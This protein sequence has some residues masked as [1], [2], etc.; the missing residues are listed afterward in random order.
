MV[1]FRAQD[2]GRTGTRVRLVCAVVP[3]LAGCSFVSSPLTTASGSE[4]LSAERLFALE[5]EPLLAA[6]CFACH[7]QDPDTV[8]SGLRLTSREAMLRGGASSKAVLV[9]GDADASLL[10]QAVR[11]TDTKLK[12]PPLEQDR[13]AA[14]DIAK[15]RA[16]IAAG[17]P[18]PETAETQQRPPPE[19]ASPP[20]PAGVT[21]ATS[22]GLSDAWTQRRYREEDLWAFRPLRRSAPPP[23]AAG[24]PIDAFLNRRLAA[25]QLKPAPRANKRTL[26]RRAT[27][28]LTGLP[29]KPADIEA[30]LHDEAPDAWT[31]AIDRLLA[32]PHYGEQWAR[33]WLDV[34]RYADTAGY[35][36]N[37]ELSNA[38]RYR[39][40][41]VRALN[42]DKPYR[43]F[44]LE[45]LA[46]DLLDPND[47]ELLVATGY[48]RMGPWEAFG[49]APAA[50]D[51]QFYLD[52]VT[53][54][55]GETFLSLPLQCAKC[56]DHKS[57]PIPTRDYYRIYAVF[58][59]TQVAKRPAPFLATENRNHFARERTRLEKLLRQAK[60]EVGRLAAQDT[61]SLVFIKRKEIRIWTR[62]LERYQPWAHAVYEGPDKYEHSEKLRMPGWLGRRGKRP[63]AYVLRGGSVDARGAAARPGAL[64]ALA[65]GFEPASPRAGTGIVP[66]KASRLALARWIASPNHPLA[67]RSI[68]NRVWHHHFGRGLAANPNDFGQAGP[69]P[70]HPALLDWLARRFVADGWSLK[71]LHRLVMTSAAYQR[72][73]RPPRRQA[74]RERDADNELLSFFPPRRL[75]AEEIRDAMLAAA[76]ELNPEVGGLPVFPEVDPQTATPRYAQ[77]SRTRAQRN[78]RSLY[79]YRS[80]WNPNP[81]FKA[82]DRPDANASCSRRATSTAA[83]QAFT[84]LHSTHSIDRSIAMAARLRQEAETPDARIDRAFH[85]AL[86]RPASAQERAWL[87][88][89][90]TEMAPYHARHPPEPTFPAPALTRKGT[91]RGFV[92]RYQ[93]VQD[94]YNNYERHTKPWEVD[95]ATRA[96]ADIC[97]ALFN[98]NEFIYVY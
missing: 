64:S 50:V 69:Q 20:A 67:T 45:Q 3:L 18:W 87:Q 46:G 93:D 89:H 97:L 32:S 43:R 2:S 16:W 48:L 29:P 35:R 1:R 36:N 60:A 85:L 15:I 7:G 72:S 61:W 91:L 74:V 80:R 13:L 27:Y 59:A 66:A 34:T 47:P 92:Y 78:R 26:I 57:D 6:K 44:V 38:W 63:E 65:L 23:A 31:R 54:A 62:R 22:G 82:F 79:L 52:D 73:D 19:P 81:L 21:V 55:V 53:N 17:A 12:M 95:P 30:F 8:Q 24:H 75:A 56:H 4:R 90:L 51:R 42:T 83:P 88:A 70:T 40:Y 68:V 76:G 33:H 25:A 39:D 49:E 86:G 77:P 58:A 84:L 11:R 96:L 10:Y 14:P 5:V 37:W 71:Q 28:D 94:V 41:V 98:S 9:P